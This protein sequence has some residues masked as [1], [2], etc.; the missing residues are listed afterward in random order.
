MIKSKLRKSAI[1]FSSLAVLISNVGIDTAYA[2]D[3][4]FPYERTGLEAPIRHQS[5]APVW[6]FTH[7]LTQTASADPATRRRES[8]P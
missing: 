4:G 5:L 7:S 1:I 3:G 8:A 6:L 2:R